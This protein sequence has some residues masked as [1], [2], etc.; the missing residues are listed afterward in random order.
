MNS[1]KRTPIF[2]FTFFLLVSCTQ[3]GQ[4]TV[5]ITTTGN[6]YHTH[7]CRY[8]GKYNIAIPLNEAEQKSYTP[9]SDCMPSG[10]EQKLRVELKRKE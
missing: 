10:K 7:N 6:Q 2:F 1:L 8:L 9:C 5:Y 3:P 4:S